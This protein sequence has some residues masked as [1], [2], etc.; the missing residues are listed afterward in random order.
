MFKSVSLSDE[1]FKSLLLFD[2]LI[3]SS[4]FFL[5]KSSM[6]ILR[7]SSGLYSSILKNLNKLLDF[8]LLN[9]FIFKKKIVSSNIL[10]F[11]VGI[12]LFLHFVNPQEKKFLFPKSS[13][14]KFIFELLL[15]TS[16]YKSSLLSLKSRFTEKLSIFIICY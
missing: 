1:E 14:L 2:K 10:N 15:L 6:L 7:F 16:M 8:D 11:N 5:F 12:K 13:Y 4:K 9:I 3:E